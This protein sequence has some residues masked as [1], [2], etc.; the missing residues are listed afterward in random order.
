[1]SGEAQMDLQIL[2]AKYSL[3]LTKDRI[4]ELRVERGQSVGVFLASLYN[5]YFDSF[6]CI[7]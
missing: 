6:V 3:L 1:M 4:C 5:G 7:T 2:I